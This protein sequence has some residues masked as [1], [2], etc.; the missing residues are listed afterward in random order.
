MVPVPSIDI[1]DEGMYANCVAA[2]MCAGF[3]SY[4]GRFPP[5]VRSSKRSFCALKYIP[6]ASTEGK[7]FV[8]AVFR[9]CRAASSSSA[10]MTVAALFRRAS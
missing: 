8:N 1:V 2:G 5:A 3:P 6:P 10:L 9:A 7:Y 4:T